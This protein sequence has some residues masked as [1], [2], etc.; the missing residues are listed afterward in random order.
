MFVADNYLLLVISLHFALSLLKRYHPMLELV[1]TY[2]L[3]IINTRATIS[4]FGLRST[5]VQD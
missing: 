1:F 3:K 4:L 5:V 2:I